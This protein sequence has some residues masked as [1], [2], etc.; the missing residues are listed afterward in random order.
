MID[1]TKP[2]SIG[3]DTF[4]SRSDESR[5]Y[6]FFHFRPTSE[7]AG[8]EERAAYRQLFEESPRIKLEHTKMLKVLKRILSGEIGR[9]FCDCRFGTYGHSSSCG[10]PALEAL[11]VEIEGN[12]A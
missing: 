9:A 3:A 10:Y 12:K 4:Y 2:I 7:P 1:L 11:I 5:E 8:D 6:P